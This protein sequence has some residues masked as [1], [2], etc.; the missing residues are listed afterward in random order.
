M[1]RE[2]TRLT[3]ARLTYLAVIACLMLAFVLAVVLPLTSSDGSV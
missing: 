2:V 3:K 1:R